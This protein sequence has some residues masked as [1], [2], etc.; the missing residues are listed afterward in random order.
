L[1]RLESKAPPCPESSIIRSDAGF[2]IF[3]GVLGCLEEH[4]MSLNRSLLKK[5]I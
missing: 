4:L 2:R 3:G 5:I 1:P